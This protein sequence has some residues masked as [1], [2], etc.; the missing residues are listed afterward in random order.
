LV[1]PEREL[2]EIIV[3]L[4]TI[5]TGYGEMG[6][7]GLWHRRDIV[8][9]GASGLE[10]QGRKPLPPLPNSMDG[11]K[12]LVL[13]CTRCTLH[14]GRKHAVF[15]EGTSNAT[16]L[17]VGEGPGEEEDLSGRPFVGEAGRLLTRIIENGMGLE[18]G[19]VYIC[20]VVKC[21]PPENRDPLDEE[22]ETCLPFLRKQI[23]LVAPR[24]ICTLGRVAGRAL[25]GGEFRM[26][27]ARGRWHAS[28]GIPVMPT[29]HPAYLLRNP[30]AKRWVWEDIKKIMNRLGLE[31]RTND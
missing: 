14:H 3:Q 1:N 10:A 29:F 24:V 20:N 23:Q 18:R 13:S 27:Q 26:K 17:F 5:L 6:L 30:S 2:K 22:M 21:R 25:L 31:V 4:K 12:D 9:C 11:L 15:G 7:D 8:P 28:Q 19:D 16:L